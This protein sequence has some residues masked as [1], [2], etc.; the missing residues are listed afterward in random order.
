MLSRF[1][2]ELTEMNKN[3][4]GGNLDKKLMSSIWVIYTGRFRNRKFSQ[5]GRGRWSVGTSK[6]SMSEMPAGQQVRL[7]VG[8]WSQA[9]RD[10]VL[11]IHHFGTSPSPPN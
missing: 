6:E 8:G 9:S 5:K 7:G 10:V 2:L 4:I 11:S 3:I 1:S